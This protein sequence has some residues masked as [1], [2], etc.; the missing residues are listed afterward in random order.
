MQIK[1][2]GLD[3]ALARRLPP[4]AWVH[5]DEALLVIEAADAIRAAFRAAG[6]TERE[7]LV[8][9]R[10]FRVDALLAQAGTMSL[11]AESR[12]IELRLSG[13]PGK[14]LGDAL[15][16]LAASGDESTRVLV[17]GPRLD[18][19][20]TGSAW[21]AELDRNA[22]SVAVYPVE[23]ARLGQWIAARLARQGQ[24]LDAGTLA[25]VAD[26]VEGNL[27]AAQ[28]EILKLGLL[29]GR[30]Q[31]AGED[32]RQAVLDV[33]RYDAFGV[34]EA[35]LAGDAARALRTLDG[36]AAEG[37]AVP[38]VLWA[39]AEAIRNLWRL[40]QARDRGENPAQLTRS[41][42]IYPPRDR[43]YLDAVRRLDTAAAER[44]MRVAAEVD[45]MAKGVAP[46]DPWAAMAHLA[47]AIAG[48]PAFCE[49]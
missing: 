4:L 8:V 16:A 21:F 26:R 39:M 47:M 37:Q 29:F 24:R 19:A 36:L 2:E 43:A 31:L 44:A 18:R 45:R 9:D 49:S 27:L 48:A 17:S 5:G 7:V 34:G 12:L 40:S 42:R 14:E 13:K 20:A 22:L 1:L 38:L 10:G 30:G 41:L 6:H 28:Q 25:F 46:G 3:A 35:M 32:V 23:R 33:A 11:F 15:A